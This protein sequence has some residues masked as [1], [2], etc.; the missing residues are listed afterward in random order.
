MEWAK[1]KIKKYKKIKNSN[2]F[3]NLFPESKMKM[4]CYVFLGLEDH[5]VILLN[6]C[7]F[8]HLKNL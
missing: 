6:F 3:I 1:K 8:F 2:F 5:M 4:C 7:F